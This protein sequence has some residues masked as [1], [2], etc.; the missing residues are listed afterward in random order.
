M[1]LRINIKIP[2]TRFII[3]PYINKSL[4]SK[5]G[6]LATQPIPNIISIRLVPEKEYILLHALKGISGDWRA[7]RKGYFH[8]H[9]VFSIEQFLGHK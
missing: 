6:R 9:I 3:K 2:D 8:I 1:K 7:I 5:R 4:L